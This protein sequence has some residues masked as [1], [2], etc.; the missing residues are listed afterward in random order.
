MTMITATTKGR[1]AGEGRAWPD[2]ANIGPRPNLEGH[3]EG[4]SIYKADPKRLRKR[5][6]T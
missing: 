4:L 1:V 2:D 3:M 6:L 5:I